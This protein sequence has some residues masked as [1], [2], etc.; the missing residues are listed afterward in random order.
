MAYVQVHNVDG[1]P[2][3]VVDYDEIK[4]LFKVRYVGWLFLFVEPFLHVPNADI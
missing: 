4:Q 3:G 1:T 2:S